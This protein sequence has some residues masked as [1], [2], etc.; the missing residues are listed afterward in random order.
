MAF[1]TTTIHVCKGFQYYFH[2]LPKT[3]KISLLSTHLPPYICTWV[4]WLTL[5]I[6]RFYLGASLTLNH[7]F[8]RD[9]TRV[10]QRSVKRV[11][12]QAQNQPFW[13]SFSDPRPILLR[14]HIF[15]HTKAH[16]IALFSIL[17]YCPHILFICMWRKIMAVYKM[18]FRGLVLY[19]LTTKSGDIYS[20]I[21][22]YCDCGW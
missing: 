3:S 13:E 19:D 2:L 9:S 5:N 14:A 11:W 16:K 12:T 7:N 8:S 6:F 18:L 17:G 20:F 15:A 1:L 22:I 4:L 10:I 21:D